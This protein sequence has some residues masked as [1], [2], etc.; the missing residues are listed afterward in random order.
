MTKSEYRLYIASEAWLQRR[1]RFLGPNPQCNRCALSQE[2]AV[3]AYDQGLNV[4]HRNYQHVGCELDEDLEAL[5]RRCHEIESNGKTAL[6]PAHLKGYD[7]I[8][9]RELVGPDLITPADV[10]MTEEGLKGIF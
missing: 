8:R 2:E 7:L 9:Y 10:H 1:K 5:C 6:P 4:H 3:R